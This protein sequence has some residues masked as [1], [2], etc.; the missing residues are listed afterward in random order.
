M[1]DA[2]YDT[3][4]YVYGRRPNDFLNDMA[5][6][7][8]Q[9]G[10]VLC[11]GE[12]EG[13]NAVWLAQRGFEVTGIDASAVGL[14]KAQKLARE[15][16]VEIETVHMDLAEADLGEARWDGIVSIFCHLPPALRKDVHARVV[17]ALKPSGIFLLEAYTVRQLEYGTGGP[18][19]AAMMM[20]LV[21]LGQELAGLAI[22]HGIETVRE[23][24]EGRFHAGQGAV[25]QLIAR[26]TPAPI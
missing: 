4:E 11:L 5:D 21:D 26:K 20:S 13:R 3:E 2:R 8:P 22:E 9:G 18:P 24:H 12:G 6:R 23:I 19:N 16:G 7:L 15:A 17:H 1:W 25:V 14:E 10:R